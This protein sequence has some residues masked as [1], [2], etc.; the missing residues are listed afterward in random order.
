MKIVFLEPLEFALETLDHACDSL[1][2]LGHEIVIYPDKRP[3]LNIERSQNAD[4][5]VQTDMPMDATFFA[6]C[7]K[8]KMLV[9]A[10]VGLDHLDLDY[11]DSHHIA[12][13]NA[14]GYSTEAVA[15]L[16]VGMMLSLYRHIAENDHVTRDWPGNAILPGLELRGKTVGLIGM[17]AIGR[18]TAELLRTFGCHLLAWNRSPILFEGVSFVDKETLLRNADIVS[19][20]LALSEETCDFLTYKDLKL[21]KKSAVLIN[22]ARGSIVNN[23]DLARALTEGL[24]AGAALDVYADEPPLFYGIPPMQA[25]NPLLSAPN[26]LLLPHIGFCTVESQQLRLQIVIDNIKGFLKNYHQ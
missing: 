10:I 18:R 3:E 16:T 21:M 13:A 7:P 11:C 24:I 19:I 6:A 20:H 4:I 25:G 12:V 17:G 8:L 22:T 14:A 26:T 15:E 5:V 23:T 9:S 2:E 1:R